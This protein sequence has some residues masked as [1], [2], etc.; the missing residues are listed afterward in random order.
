MAQTLVDRYEIP[1]ALLN[2]AVGG[3]TIDYHLRNDQD[4][5]DLETNYGRLLY[6]AQAAGIDTRASAILW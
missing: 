1:I 4:P 5:T 2:G 3:T 6:R